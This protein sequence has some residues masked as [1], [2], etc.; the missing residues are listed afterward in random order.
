MSKI[1]LWA[2]H[3][4]E[5]FKNSPDAGHPLCLCSKCG[6]HIDEDEVPIRCWSEKADIEYRWHVECFQELIDEGIVNF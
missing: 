2:G 3:G 5:Q 1:N 6:K 4:Q